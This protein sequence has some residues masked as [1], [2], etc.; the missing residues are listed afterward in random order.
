M[1]EVSDWARGLTQY[2][3]QGPPH[4]HLWRTNKMQSVR[5]HRL[6]SQNLHFNQTPR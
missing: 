2:V 1:K 6:L 4:Q 5:P 3:D